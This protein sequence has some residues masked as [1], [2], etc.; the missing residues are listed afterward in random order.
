[1]K[2][3]FTTSGSDLEAPLNSTFGR[4]P[5]FLVYDLAGGTYTVVDNRQ[6]LSASQGAG[7][8]AAQA[9][10]RAG[11]QCLVS[12]H[13]GPKA[14]RVLSAAGIKVFYTEAP[15]VSAALSEYVS[16]KLAEAQ[17]ADVQEHHA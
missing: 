6:N 17:S 4:A 1:M 10:I 8:Q 15:T 5:G 3:A 16:G 9:L 13:C 14:F 12:G 11:A 2:I 7:V